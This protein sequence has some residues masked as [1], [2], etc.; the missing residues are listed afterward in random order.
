MQTAAHLSW[1]LRGRR[2]TA[3]LCEGDM[4]QLKVAKA[5]AE[6]E[7]AEAAA[8]AATP[9]VDP[10]VE[11]KEKFGARFDEY[12]KIGYIWDSN[13]LPFNSS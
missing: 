2:A 12:R 1:A 13:N 9:A 4:W 10:D 7:A 3:E 11:L 8:I 5:A 6:A